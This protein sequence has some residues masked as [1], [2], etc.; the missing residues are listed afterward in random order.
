MTILCDTNIISELTRPRPNPNVVIWRQSIT[1][2]AIS[3]VTVEETNYGLAA[4]PNTRIQSWFEQFTQTNCQ[5][6]AITDAIAQQAGI[7]RGTLQTQG[8]PRTQADMLIAATAQVH[9][10]VLVT[11]NTRDFEDCSIAL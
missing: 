7:L 2:I 9:Q 8:K 1:T 5:T 11:R 3:V 6:L 4:K 10:L